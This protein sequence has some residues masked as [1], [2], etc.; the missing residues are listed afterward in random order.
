MFEF[1]TK[2][3]LL[4]ACNGS[5]RVH[6]CKL[7]LRRLGV[8]HGRFALKALF[9]EPL[10]S[11]IVAKSSF[12]NDPDTQDMGSARQ[13]ARV[14]SSYLLYYCIYIQSQSCLR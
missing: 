11:E 10:K 5:I 3:Y 6:S 14:S 8:T 1:M 2:R 9:L 7:A 4:T 12:L 13:R